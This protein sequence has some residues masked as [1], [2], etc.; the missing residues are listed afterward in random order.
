MTRRVRSLSALSLL[1][2]CAVLHAAGQPGSRPAVLPLDS[3]SWIAGTWLAADDVGVQ[4]GVWFGPSGGS[5]AGLF[6]VSEGG[7]VK[8]YEVYLLEQSPAGP[9]LSRRTYGPSLDPGED[10]E[11]WAP[12]R[13]REVRDTR[14]RF[15]PSAPG[16]VSS[17][18]I[19]RT[20]NG[21]LRITVERPH[22]A[23]CS[24]RTTEYS[25]KR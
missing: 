24:L 12:L 6:R 7:K 8:R 10:D 14:V 18:T 4:E 25:P 11:R 5:M 2:L 1:M 19:E 21:H 16:A 9:M 20:G 15:S 22:D 17:V 23:G 13:I 3:L